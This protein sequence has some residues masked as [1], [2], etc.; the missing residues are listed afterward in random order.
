MVYFQHP[1]YMS[2]SKGKKRLVTL[3]RVLSKYGLA[4][5]TEA[6]GWIK[7]GR[8]SVNGKTVRQPESWVRLPTDVV[9]L[10]GLRLRR[11]RPIYVL[12]NKPR[13]LITT[14][15]D[16]R[17]RGTVYECLSDIKQWIFPVGRLDKNTSGL[18]VLTNDTQL[19][20]RLTN[21]TSQIPK[22]YLVKTNG[23]L[24]PD[25]LRALREGVDIG[26]GERSQPAHVVVSR[27]TEKNTWLEITIT[28]GKNRQVRRMLEAV[29]HAVL[30]LVR[31]RVGPLTLDG[32]PVGRYRRLTSGEVQALKRQ[33][34]NRE[35]TS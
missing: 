24:S 25:Q 12:L 30:K 15:S 2:R 14:R 21:P 17:G 19:A 16:E 9:R 18:L 5:R 33:Y 29:A 10:D 8:V 7:E 34:F 13:G 4:S 6:V 23:Q 20:E 3:D 11:Q 26:R 1:V 27:A 35:K 32:L 31:I 28:E 22:T